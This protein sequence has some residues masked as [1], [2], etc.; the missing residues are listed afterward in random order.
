V[1]EPSPKTEVFIARGGTGEGGVGAGG[2][3]KNA[4]GEKTRKG[5]GIIQAQKGSLP[6]GV[7]GD[8]WPDLGKLFAKP[9]CRIAGCLCWFA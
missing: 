8:G 1:W 4:D 9:E 3:H 5:Q 6:H 7:E 2:K